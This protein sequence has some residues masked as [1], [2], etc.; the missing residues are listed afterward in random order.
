MRHGRAARHSTAQ[1][2][3][4]L[5]DDWASRRPAP[6]HSRLHGHYSKTAGHC[7]GG[8]I[9]HG[10]SLGKG[11]RRP[12]M[13]VNKCCKE[14]W[15]HAV[16]EGTSL[17][18]ARWGAGDQAPQATAQMVLV[19]PWQPTWR[20][21]KRL[22]G[23]A[24]RRA[25]AW[26]R[27]RRCSGAH[28]TESEGLP[29]NRASRM[30]S[31]GV[32]GT[33]QHAKHVRPVSRAPMCA[34][35]PTRFGATRCMQLNMQQATLACAAPGKHKC[36]SWAPAGM[37]LFLVGHHFALPVYGQGSGANCSQCVLKLQELLPRQA[38][39]TTL[40]WTAA[41]AA[42]CRASPLRARVRG[43]LTRHPAC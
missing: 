43:R 14:L 8:P 41:A 28:V 35:C 15:R 11:T 19:P 18:H 7:A 17:V 33:A 20:L 36:Y 30:T 39:A 5:V 38:A 29:C 26:R 25:R 21:A 13:R 6:P 3:R 37:P 27:G 4:G 40:R 23:R 31:S 2:A 34:S 12:A 9:C 16:T 24:G 10:D 22:R 32:S 1:H 42:T